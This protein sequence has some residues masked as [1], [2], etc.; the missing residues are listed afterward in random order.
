[1]KQV[2]TNVKDII[3]VYITEV[4]SG[5]DTGMLTENDFTSMSTDHQ[6]TALIRVE[7]DAP[8][9]E[10]MDQVIETLKLHVTDPIPAMIVS[11]AYGEEHEIDFEELMPL[12]ERIDLLANKQTELVWDM[13]AK[14]DL[15]CKR[16]VL[17]FVFQ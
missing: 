13:H 14:E 1:M 12:Q 8:I 3:N 17:V 4:L 7:D 15:K 11:M 16:S 2:I 10:L 9:H 6:P 5:S